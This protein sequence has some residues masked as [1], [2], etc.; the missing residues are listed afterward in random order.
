MIRRS[1]TMLK[2]IILIFLLYTLAS[3]V[4]A[5]EIRGQATDIAISAFTWDY[6]NFA[7]FN[8]GES[9]TIQPSDVDVNWST[10]TLSDMQDANV[11]R[12]II[13]LTMA[14]PM[15]F[16]FKQWGEYKVIDFLADRYFAAYDNAVTTTMQQ[17]NL[18]V[19]YLADVS[20]NDNLMTNEQIS[21]VLIDNSTEI[22]ITSGDSIKLKEGYELVFKGLDVDGKRM[23]LE[24][25]KDGK[26]V[27][28][29]VIQPSIANAGMGDSTYY[30]RTNIGDTTD[31]VQIAVHFKDVSSQSN[32]DIAVADGVFQISD[33]PIPL[34]VDQQYDKMSIRQ[35]DSTALTIMMDNKNQPIRL[36]KNMD[37]L[38]MG[39]IHLKTL[40][41]N[42][43]TNR[44]QPLRYYIYSDE[45]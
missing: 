2:L 27:Q 6:T 32:K 15:N 5:I 19:P 12:G 43:T 24:L 36:E 7:G 1:T 28:A 26:T 41:N 30:Y 18:K 34:K 23:F 45:G 44:I 29:R 8:Y 37:I 33:S 35:V 20:K 16:K 14:R 21:K 11:N 13:Y 17:D 9:L 40:D 31:I 25:R 10:A 42:T 3:L 4:D 38:L 39:Y 22:K